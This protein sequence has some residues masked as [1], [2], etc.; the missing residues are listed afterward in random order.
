MDEMITRAND[1]LLSRAGILLVSNFNSMLDNFLLLIAH[2]CG[3]RMRDDL[4]S[5]TNLLNCTKIVENGRVI[6]LGSSGTHKKGYTRGQNDLRGEG[7]HN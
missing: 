5:Q 7:K 4:A 2:L 3:L 1:S 6:D